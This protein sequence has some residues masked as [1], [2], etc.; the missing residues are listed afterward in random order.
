MSIS[1]ASNTYHS[2]YYQTHSL[3]DKNSWLA[4]S[5]QEIADLA[6]Q[7]FSFTQNLKILDLGCGV[8]KNSIPLA[9]QLLANDPKIIAV[10]I[11]PNAIELLQKNAKKYYV[12]PYIHGIISPI[13]SFPIVEATYDLILAN[14]VLMF[15]DSF[16]SVELVLKHMIHGTKTGGFNYI[17]VSTDTK[18]T[19]KE[20]T[21]PA[22]SDS[23]LPFELH[24]TTQ[25]FQHFYKDWTTHTLSTKPY[26]EYYQK[27]GKFYHWK[28]TFLTCIFQK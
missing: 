1:D 5:E 2:H 23:E 11:L 22:I 14:S 6:S 25:L 16:E 15:L 12:D 26:E 10:D 17:C 4:Q 18:E 24:D 13:E 28:T 9:Q 8:G 21:I 7:N 3:F 19:Q 20:S 27:N